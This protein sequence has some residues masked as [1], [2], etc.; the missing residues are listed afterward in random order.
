MTSIQSKT[1]PVKQSGNPSELQQ[2]VFLQSLGQ[3]DRIVLVVRLQTAPQ[4][5]VVLLFNQQIVVSLVDNGK[6]ELLRSN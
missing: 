3:L 6:V 1:Y 4:S 5:D 2:L